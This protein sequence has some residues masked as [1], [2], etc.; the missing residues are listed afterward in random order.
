MKTCEISTGR[1]VSNM[2]MRGIAIY[3][4]FFGTKVLSTSH[5]VRIA[6]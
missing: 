6:L 1:S 4:S 3:F 5:A 2:P